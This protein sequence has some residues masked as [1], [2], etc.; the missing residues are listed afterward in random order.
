MSHF[1]SSCSPPNIN[2]TPTY[3][4]EMSFSTA[5]LNYS[6]FLYFTIGIISLYYYFS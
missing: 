6:L 3:D 4:V 2:M 5:L 1:G